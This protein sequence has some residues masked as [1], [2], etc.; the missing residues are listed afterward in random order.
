MKP[1]GVSTRFNEQDILNSINNTM[2]RDRVP[3][4]N[5]VLI[6]GASMEGSAD[7]VKRRI[8]RMCDEIRKYDPDMPI[9]LM[10]LPPSRMEDMDDYRKAGVTEVGFNIEIFSP[11]IARRY[12]P[13]KSG[14]TLSRYITALRY[15]THVWVKPGSVRSA[16][17]VG[18]EPVEKTLEAVEL[19]ASLGVSPILSIFRPVPGTDLE[20]IMPLSSEELYD[21]VEKAFRICERYGVELGPDC[22]DC[23]NNTLSAPHS[24]L[25]N[26]FGN[27]P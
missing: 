6:G 2:G 3:N 26:T 20:N 1:D 23:Q 10:C 18:L 4:V 8:I 12:M 11:E 14:L 9:Y 17:I 24:V 19:L 22:I 21:I 15:A 13:G 5:H 7:V 25:I 27:Q 16:L